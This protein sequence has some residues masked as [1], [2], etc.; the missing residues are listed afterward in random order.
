MLTKERYSIKDMAIWTRKETLFFLF[1]A[2]FITMLY[3]VFDFTFLESIL[4]SPN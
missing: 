4:N 2:L 1:Y 3:E